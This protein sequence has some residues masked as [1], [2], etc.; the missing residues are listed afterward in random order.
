MHLNRSG[1][2]DFSYSS[3]AFLHFCFAILTEIV[4][5]YRNLIGLSKLA[6]IRCD[7]SS[8]N[9]RKHLN[10]LIDSNG[11]GYSIHWDANVEKFDCYI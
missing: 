3:I 7:Q 2:H 4:R 1:F 6:N 8:N 9:R 5:K 11:N 10:L